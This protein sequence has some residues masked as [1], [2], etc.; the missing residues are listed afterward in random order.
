MSQ[1]ELSTD[2]APARPTG[3]G[4]LK[5]RM[6]GALSACM[7]PLMQRAARAYVGGVSLDDALSVAQRLAGEGTPTTLG[8]WNAP[9]ETP[10][11]VA[12]E[13]RASIDRVADAGLDS[14]LSIKPPA[15]AFDA[16]LATEVATSAAARGVRLH[17]DSHGVEVA[18]PSCA[19]METMRLHLDATEISSTLPGRWRRSLTDAD[20]SVERNFKVR[21]VKGQWPDPGEPERDM[22]TGFLELIDRLAGRGL[23][24]A[25]ASHNVP[26]AAE[27]IAQLRAAGTSFEL[28]LLF[29]LPMTQSIRW[30]REHDVPV[31]IY[32]PYG[33]GYIPHAI[34][35]LWRN[36]RIMWW[37]AKDLVRI[38]R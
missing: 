14:Y 1:T 19:M 27:A 6:R 38:R 33:Q 34:D 16:E 35:Q 12:D 25:V 13:Y 22:A 15:L 8:F 11:Q 2:T 4:G 24:V 37:I 20:W 26:L 28:E 7:L 36:P 31:R 18:D 10:R 9:E 30:A 23:H 29:G 32:V 5:W 21:V 17:C 3:L